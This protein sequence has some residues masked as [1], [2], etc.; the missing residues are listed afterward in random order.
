MK[1]VDLVASRYARAI[2]EIAYERNEIKKVHESLEFINNIYNQ[3]IEFKNF[4]DNPLIDEESKKNVLGNLLLGYGD[5][6]DIILY[7]LS[8]NRLGYIKNII[9]EFS[10][11]FYLNNGILKVK[12]TFTRDLT[13]EERK[14]LQN[15]LERR[16]GKKID[17]KIKIDK[18]ILGGGIIK[19]GDQIID[20]SLKNE[21]NKLKY[22][23]TKLL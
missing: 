2:Y 15:N 10:K 7:L 9:L 6:K 20:G 14:I 3:D 13:E 5:T 18:T 21:L 1:T 23:K 4:M 22:N 16:T 17:L 11:L 19:I 12:A 8:K